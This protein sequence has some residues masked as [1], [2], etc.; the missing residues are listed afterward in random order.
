MT[1]SRPGTSTVDALE[2]I[3]SPSAPSIIGESRVSVSAN[4]R[5]ID[6]RN[7]AQIV[8]NGEA[9]AA[10][11]TNFVEGLTKVATPIIKDQLTK[12]AKSQLGELIEADPGIVEK[13]RKAGPEA[14]ELVR[15]LSPQAQDMFS[16]MVAESAAMN[17]QERLGQSAVINKILIDPSKRGTPEEAAAWVQVKSDALEQSGL[18]SLPPALLGTMADQLGTLEGQ[19]KGKLYGLQVRESATQKDAVMSNWVGQSFRAFV[20]SRI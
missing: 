6:G 17:Y 10:E 18:K 8:K 3:S 20:P 9:R 14:R 5:V 12:Q 1:Y 4:G 2:R 7:P 15:T 19:I 13:A 16:G 11:V